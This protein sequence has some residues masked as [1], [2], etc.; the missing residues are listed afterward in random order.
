MASTRAGFF[1]VLAVK[2]AAARL[3]CADGIS[4]P[5]RQPL[6]PR[7]RWHCRRVMVHNHP[8]IS[9]LHEREAV[10]RRKRLGFSV[11]HKRKGVVSR[12]D[13]GSAIRT[14]QL[15]TE[16]YLEIRQH[17]ERCNERVAQCRSIRSHGWGE[18]S[19]ED[20]IRGVEGNHLIR[21]ILSYGFAPFH[22]RRSDILFWSGGSTRCDQ[23][24]CGAEHKQKSISHDLPPISIL[25]ERNP[26][27][28][29]C[30]APPRELSTD[31]AWRGI[32]ARCRGRARRAAGV[33]RR[34]RE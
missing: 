30:R 15:L 7:G 23:E 2:V 17:L 1:N 16:C 20:R 32:A 3:C 24:D 13:G 25:S 18:R 21:I 4:L 14:D 11:F 26:A 28:M 10:P 8:V 22:R 34:Q 29:W 33:S 12:I 31:R 19:P 9:V 27:V 5:S 6:L